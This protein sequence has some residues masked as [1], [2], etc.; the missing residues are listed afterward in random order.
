MKKYIIDSS[1]LDEL[2]TRYPINIVVFEPIYTKL[3]QMF[4]DGELF[5]VREVFEELKDSQAYWDDYEECFRELT[6]QESENVAKILGDSDFSVFVNHGM[7]ENDGYWADPHLISCAMEDPS[8]TIV[9]EE[10]SRNHPQR[11]IPYV[12]EQK[13]IRCI[14]VLEFLDEIDIM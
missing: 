1:S 14:K 8:I 12:C 9:S 10:S 11:K 7:E 4:G 6:E 2:E 13:G 3:N 5:S